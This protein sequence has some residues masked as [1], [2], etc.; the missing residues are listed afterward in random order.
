VPSALAAGALVARST[1][2]AIAMLRA[3]GT[4]SPSRK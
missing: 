4:L 3:W 2:E 1:D